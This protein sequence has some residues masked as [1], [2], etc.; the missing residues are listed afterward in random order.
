MPNRRKKHIFICGIYKIT[1]PI[2]QIYI[3]QSGDL[4]RRWRRSQYKT[5]RL[6]VN[7]F[8]LY[9]HKNHIFEII[10]VC[11]KEM[12]NE[13]EDYW[14]KFY[15]CFDTPHGL[16]L[17]SGNLFRKV[18]AETRRL[19]SIGKTGCTALRG[20]KKTKEHAMKVGKAHKKTVLNTKTGIYY[21]GAV[22]AYK[23]TNYSHKQFMAM[24]SGHA[25]NKTP[26]IYA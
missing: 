6:I 21:E 9:G 24:L 18:C 12:L 10:E 17:N 3:G 5:Q 19:L 22:D 2:G 1:N 26:F 23:L 13:R 11:K 8:D 25:K 4:Y 7:S 14:I 16:N 20:I 15:D